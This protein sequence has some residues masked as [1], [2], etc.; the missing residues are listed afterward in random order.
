M[1]KHLLPL[2]C[3]MALAL[4]ACDEPVVEDATPPSTVRMTLEFPNETK[5]FLQADDASA[6]FF[7][8]TCYDWNTSTDL[9][10]H[11]L[12]V[13]LVWPDD[14]SFYSPT[15]WTTGT[16]DMVSSATYECTD[17]HAEAWINT[18]PIAGWITEAAGDYTW[19]ETAGGVLSVTEYTE[20]E[21]FS[22]GTVSLT[23]TDTLYIEDGFGTALSIVPLSLT[24]SNCELY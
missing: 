11:I 6:V 13:D 7:E 9:T 16:F 20:G 24:A 10:S 1:Q 12:A 5:E 18:D 2:M 21:G 22:P 23:W 8:G 14:I 4:N 15:P 17:L 19:I 3:A